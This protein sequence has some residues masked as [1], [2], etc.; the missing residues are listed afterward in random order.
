[1]TNKE[2]ILERDR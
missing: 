1:L 2:S